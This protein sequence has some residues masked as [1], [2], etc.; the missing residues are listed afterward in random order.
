MAEFKYTV[1]VDCDFKARAVRKVWLEVVKED[2]TRE[3]IGSPELR[4]FVPVL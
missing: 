2:P 1:D 3:L 4:L